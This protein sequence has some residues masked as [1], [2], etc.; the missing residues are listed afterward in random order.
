[1]AQDGLE[2]MLDFLDLL[3]ERKVHFFIEQYK[4]DSLTVTLTLVGA[5]IEVDFFSDHIEYSVFEGSEAVESDESALVR[6]V[7]ADTDDPNSAAM[8]QDYR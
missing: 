2:R 7:K 6:R 4:E 1:M 3:R 8:T 5:R